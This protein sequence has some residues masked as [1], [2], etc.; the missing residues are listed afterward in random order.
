MTIGLTLLI[1]ND[2]E[3][4]KKVM[5]TYFKFFDTVYILNHN[6]DDGVVDF[7]KDLHKTYGD[8]CNL[9]IY[10]ES[11]YD[12]DFAKARNFLFEQVKEDYVM[13]FDSDDEVSPGDLILWKQFIN[14]NDHLEAVYLPYWYV[15]DGDQ[16]YILQYRE[17]IFKSPKDWVWKGVIHETCHSKHQGAKMDYCHVGKVLHNHNK[18]K[19]NREDSMGRNYRI[20]SSIEE[21]TPMQIFYLF[22][23]SNA[24]YDFLVVD[25]HYKKFESTIEYTIKTD[26]PIIYDMIWD[27]Y[28]RALVSYYKDKEKDYSFIKS[29]IEKYQKKK[30]SRLWTSNKS[31]VAYIEAIDLLEG[32]THEF[33]GKEGLLARLLDTPSNTNYAIDYTLY[34]G[35]KS[36]KQ[37][38]YY[39]SKGN[40]VN[41]L[42]YLFIAQSEYY[43]TV[44][45]TEYYSKVL[46]Y[47][48]I[49][50]LDL[51][52]V[53]SDSN[54]KIGDVYNY[55]ESENETLVMSVPKKVIQSSDFSEFCY[56][57]CL[58]FVEK[59]SDFYKILNNTKVNVKSYYKEEDVN[60][61][62]WLRQESYLLD[63]WRDLYSTSYKWHHIYD[64]EAESEVPS[65]LKV[66][67][68]KE[69]KLLGLR[70]PTN[71][72]IKNFGFVET[73]NFTT[74]VFSYGKPDLSI[75]DS[76]LKGKDVF[77][78]MIKSEMSV[79]FVAGGAEPWDGKSTNKY[80]IGASETSLINLA[81]SLA[82]MFNVKVFCT[83]E[84]PS[85]VQGVEYL[86]MSYWNK[87]LIKK[88]DVLISSRLPDILNERYCDNQILWI[89][90]D[91][92]TF[93]LNLCK[94]RE[95]D[96]IVCVSDA[97]KNRLLS[98]LKFLNRN[99]VH[100][101]HN[102][103]DLY[104][105]KSLNRKKGRLVFMSSPDR[106]IFNWDDLKIDKSQFEQFVFYGWNNFSSDTSRLVCTLREKYRLRKAGYNVVGRVDRHS[107][108]QFLPTCEF[109]PYFS[110]FFETFCAS[111]VE[112]MFHGVKVITDN[113]SGMTEALSV[114]SP[115]WQRTNKVR[116]NVSPLYSVP[117]PTSVDEVISKAKEFKISSNPFS[118]ENL[119]K[120]WIDLFYAEDVQS[121][122][123]SSEGFSSASEVSFL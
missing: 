93:Y 23:E 53:D 14:N 10:N 6:S 102:I 81:T 105:V 20:L 47:V 73:E 22:R 30:G 50:N 65:K 98:K 55:I 79:F 120:K 117:E 52:M 38:E 100:T 24:I 58:I 37:S 16:P 2:I 99:R 39:F 8:V 77:P 121:S 92:E 66:I 86:P 27:E 109:M 75:V 116:H 63:N 76:K 41:A 114:L 78:V 48:K 54:W 11:S 97:Q 80:G 67:L 72:L 46:N 82:P 35:Y 88:G 32:T 112:S 110:D 28:L 74:S 17:R 103:V 70:G 71:S 107:L 18:F 68:S 5:P 51:C 33:L 36:F 91:P 45:F 108:M 123:F 13:W 94:E 122:L 85:T 89:H 43:P 49:K 19:K 60:D 59:L 83:T 9:K 12:L 69:N 62:T 118:G 34:N 104:R 84:K 95:I 119:A 25:S 26:H 31:I 57:N 64:K 56:E 4:I 96:H 29:F 111:A 44:E 113:T 87:N 1:K 101:I 21:P 90:D 3:N 15:Y 40:I 42:R 115:E 7:V 106:A 61:V